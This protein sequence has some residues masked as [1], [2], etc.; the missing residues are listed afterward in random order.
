MEKYLQPLAALTSPPVLIDIGASGEPPR[1]WDAIRTKAVYLGFDP[2]RRELHD[3]PDGHYAR[4]IIVNKALTTSAENETK[5][6]LTYSPYCSSTLRPDSKS[7]SN[8]LFSDLFVVEQEVSVPATTIA[9]ILDQFSLPGIDWFKTDSQGTDLR[10]FQ[11]LPDNIRSQVLAVDIEPGLIDA[12]Q[13]EDLFVEA[14]RELLNQGFWLSNLQVC[15]SIRLRRSTASK[16]GEHFIPMVSSTQ[17]TSPGWCEARYLRDQDWLVKI[18]ATKDRFLLLWVFA[19]LDEQY[20]FALD[21]AEAYMRCFGSDEWTNLIQNEP[22][23]ILETKA[24]QNN[25]SPSLLRRA[26]RKFGRML[27]R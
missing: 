22:L 26:I 5:F 2:D 20:G 4:S 1:I 3:V 6:Y 10:L 16:L 11:S 15:G 25:R 24:T 9:G 12:Y 23:T 8:Y 18:G 17:R 19:M 13:G 14:H 7:L 21:V 27:I